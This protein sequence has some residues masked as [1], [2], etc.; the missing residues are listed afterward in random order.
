MRESRVPGIYVFSMLNFGHIL[1]SDLVAFT[2]RYDSTLLGCTSLHR[3]CFF[4][5]YH[6]CKV[7]NN[8][9]K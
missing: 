2:S 9:Y 4:M 5:R 1:I 6:F 8:C 7:N 3:R